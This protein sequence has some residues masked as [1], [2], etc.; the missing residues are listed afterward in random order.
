MGI[1]LGLTLWEEHRL[2]MFER[3]VLR[4]IFG[5]EMDEIMGS[6]RKS[7]NGEFHKLYFLQNII[8]IFKLR[9]MGKTCTKNDERRGLPTGFWWESQKERDN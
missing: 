7:R 5:P 4:R 1:K 3:R 2:R 6:W 8:T 9:R